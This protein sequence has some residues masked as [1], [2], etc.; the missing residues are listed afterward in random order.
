M[1]TIAIDENYV[2]ASDS[3]TSQAGLITSQNFVK[4]FQVRDNLIAGAGSICEI[5]SFLLDFKNNNKTT[6]ADLDSCQIVILKKK[7][8]YIVEASVDER[9]HLVPINPP[10]AIGS[11]GEIALGAMLAGASAEESVKLASMIDVFTNN[12]VQVYSNVNKTRNRNR[13]R[14]LD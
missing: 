7:K 6:S 8:L 12:N 2:L 10:Y 5:K 14:I 4:V 3:R 1:T 9:Y 13:K 11:G